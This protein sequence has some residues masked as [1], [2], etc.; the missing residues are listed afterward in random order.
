MF[1]GVHQGLTLQFLRIIN[2]MKQW[3]DVNHTVF[4]T[5]AQLAGAFQNFLA[6][7]DSQQDCDKWRMLLENGIMAAEASKKDKFN[8]ATIAKRYNPSKSIM[9]TCPHNQPFPGVV[10]TLVVEVHRFA[11][12]TEASTWIFFLLLVLEGFF[13]MIVI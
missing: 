10:Y 12:V 11:L 4:K 6:Y 9:T 5:D 1:F 2:F 13:L 8:P 7:L 3:I